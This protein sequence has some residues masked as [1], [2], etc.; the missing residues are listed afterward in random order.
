M[1]EVA[2]MVWVQSLAWELP[3]AISA[4]KKEKEDLKILIN[5]F[6]NK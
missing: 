6:K 4:E 3:H 2:A 5:F 1:A